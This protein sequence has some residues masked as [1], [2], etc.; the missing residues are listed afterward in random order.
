MHHVVIVGGGFGGLR[1]AKHLAREPVRVTLVDSRNF[2]LFQPLLYQV[3]TGGL[4]PAN[5][6]TPLRGMFRYEENVEV[7][8]GRVSDID[9]EKRQ[10]VLDGARIDYDTLVLAT[11]SRPSYFGHDD[12][13]ACAPGLKSIEDALTIRRRVLL[14]FEAAERETDPARVKTLLTFVI[15]GGGPS[16]V[17]LAGALSEIANHSL[18]HEFRTIN[19]SDARIY[20]FDHAPR[21]LGAFS[22]DLSKYAEATLKQL[23]VIVRSGVAVTDIEEDFIVVKTGEA[24]ERI[25]AANAFWAAGVHASPLGKILAE[26]TGVAADHSGRVPV[27]ADLCIAGHPEI[28][29]LGDLALCSGADGK[30]LPGVAQVAI[31]QGK[32]A[33]GLVKSRLEGKTPAP[34]RYKNRGSMATIGRSAAVVQMPRLSFT[35]FPAWLLWLLVHMMSLVQFENRILVF[36]QWFWGYATWSRSACLITE[37]D[38]DAD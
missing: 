22:E 34:F 8:L 7:L 4:S 38:N 30:P 33:A 9:V 10:I 31:Q 24:E 26:K 2:H 21:V 37:N 23:G 29:V 20:V 3:A 18:K 27:G 36:I 14:A 16:G 15:I 17:E 19:P 11:G 6:A 25:P 12:W 35:G 13:R 5:I 32:Y 1:A 28:L